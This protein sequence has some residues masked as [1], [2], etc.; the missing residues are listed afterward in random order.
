MSMSNLLKSLSNSE[1]DNFAPK[2]YRSKKTALCLKDSFSSK[3]TSSI[4]SAKILNQESRLT[5][6]QAQFL[7]FL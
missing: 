4:F 7:R 6:F 3:T 5:S 1:E 2:R